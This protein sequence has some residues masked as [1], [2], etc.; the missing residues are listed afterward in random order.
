MRGEVHKAVSCRVFLELLRQ[1]VK[2][3]H[4]TERFAGWIAN[5]YQIYEKRLAVQV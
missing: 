4:G 2:H 3:G 1:I 5:G